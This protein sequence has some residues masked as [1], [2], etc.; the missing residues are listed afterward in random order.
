MNRSRIANVDQ[1]KELEVVTSFG[2]N[3]MEDS[4]TECMSKAS[5]HLGA[6]D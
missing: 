6:V 2:A 4:K 3:S 1:D 5:N